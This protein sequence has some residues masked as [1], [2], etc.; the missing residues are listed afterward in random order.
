[1]KRKTIFAFS[2]PVVLL[3][4]MPAVAPSLHQRRQHAFCRA[5]W[6]GKT[7]TMKVLFAFGANVS[8][9]SPAYVNPLAA[10]SESG[11]PGAIDFMLNH[12]ANVNQVDEH[13]WTPL[14]Y[15][16][17]AGQISS[18]R[19]LLSKGADVNAVGR[20][21]SASH[22]AARVNHPEIIKLLKDAG[23]TR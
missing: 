21:G 15:A 11:S 3:L 9:C 4:T 5:A 14:M 18:V 6:L 1:M 10:A 22:I 12:G 23:A 2:L 8:E 13:G 20:F 19:V 17:A 7:N 16:A